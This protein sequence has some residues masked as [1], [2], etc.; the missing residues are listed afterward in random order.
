VL[1]NLGTAHSEGFLSMQ[2]SCVKAGRC[3]Q[4]R[5]VVIGPQALLSAHDAANIDMEQEAGLDVVIRS[6]QS[7][8]VTPPYGQST[9]KKNQYHHSIY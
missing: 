5:E 9:R 2:K 4:K 7:E 1:T 8:T 6:V 3:L